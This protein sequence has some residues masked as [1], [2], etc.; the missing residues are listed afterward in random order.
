[1]LEAVTGKEGF[2]LA[3]DK[4][5]DLVISDVMMPVMSGIE[6]C[7][8]LKTS[9]ITSH[10]P[11]VLLTARA[12]HESKLEGLRTGADDYVA[13]PFNMH[14]LL[15]RVQN[16]ILQRAKL[17]EKYHNHIVV[18]PHEITVT[19]L[20]ERFIQQVIAIVEKNLDNPSFDVGKLTEEAGISRT[21]L[22]RKLK[23]ITGMSASEFVQDFR[24]KRAAILMEKKADTITQ[25][26]F[27][28]GFN[29]QSYFTKCFRKK[30]GKTPSEFL[31][32]EFEMAG[33]ENAG[34][35]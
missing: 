18:Q 26:A 10:L 23:A 4:E 3:R 12:D 24:L 13:K 11:V 21:N 2:A 7:H 1:V 5:V 14:E 17:I 34:A 28:V 22:H 19:P 9:E 27:R 35:D 32:K 20:D 30:F 6:L 25:I 29:D 8:L 16:L 33:I 31:N 15:A